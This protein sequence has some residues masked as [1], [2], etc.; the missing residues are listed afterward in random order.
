MN[1]YLLNTSLEIVDVIDSYKSLIWTTKYFE[2]GDFELYLPASEKMLNALQRDYYLVRE[3]DMTQA[4]IIK[5]I[6]I[7]T[8]VEEGNYLIVTGKCL[9]SILNRRVVWEQTI[10]SGTVED[11]I[12]RLVTENLISSPVAERNINNLILGAKLGVSTTMSSQYTGDNLG[13]V[14]TKLCK[15]YGL[16]F[17][18]LLD[19]D[20]K[21]FIFILYQ[22]IDRSFNQS[23][24]P[25]VTFSNEFENLR[26]TTYVCNSDEFRNV[27][28][29]AGEGEGKTRK[30][31]T[32]GAGAGLDRYEIF[33]DAR[34]VSSNEGE[35]DSA[36]YN[37]L[38]VEKG[39]EALT[40]T[41]IKESIEGEVEPNH[42]YR[43]NRDY[44]LGDV[45]EL[46][47]EYGMSMTPRITEVIETVDENGVSVIPTF[48]TGEEVE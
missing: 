39:T 47:N 35:V 6:Q 12:R 3:S 22:G 24:N 7:T 11:G 5:N 29:V 21:K 43:L 19:L 31:A 4:M 23:V 26:T 13:E 1:I 46:V 37:S 15:S 45:V 16:G 48:S 14:V 32:V 30:S 40:G 8:N 44:F 10:L 33:V 9:K 20:E 18:I 17:D 2:A 36:T 38:L 41:V 27:A 28:K 34:D 42:T 25:R